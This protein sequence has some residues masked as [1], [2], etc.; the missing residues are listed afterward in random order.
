[1]SDDT[2]ETAFGPDV[3]C[4]FHKNLYSDLRELQDLMVEKPVKPGSMIDQVAKFFADNIDTLVAKGYLRRWYKT[5]YETYDGYDSDSTD[6]YNVTTCYWQDYVIPLGMYVVLDTDVEDLEY[7]DLGYVGSLSSFRDHVKADSFIYKTKKV[8]YKLDEYVDE[9]KQ[10]YDRY[11]AVLS[12]FL[13]GLEPLYKTIVKLNLDDNKTNEMLRCCY[14][15][16]SRALDL[17][18]MN[19]PLSYCP[20]R[21]AINRLDRRGQYYYDRVNKDW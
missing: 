6:R 2:G 11:S 9:I 13:G 4:V 17:V 15:M 16:A 12:K 10:R 18:E 14:T 5:K 8:D 1:M 19:K 21:V 7:P 3:G 20:M